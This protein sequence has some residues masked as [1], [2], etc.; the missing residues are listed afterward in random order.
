MRVGRLAY[1]EHL[2]T[3]V[4]RVN[5]DRHFL[6][7]D[8]IHLQRR[9]LDR[10]FYGGLR[11]GRGGLCDSVTVCHWLHN[12]YQLSCEE[13]LFEQVTGVDEPVLTDCGVCATMCIHE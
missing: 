10:H 8:E 1:L 5:C 6:A 4:R 2:V 3:S 7:I 9:W 12:I 11:R 13:E